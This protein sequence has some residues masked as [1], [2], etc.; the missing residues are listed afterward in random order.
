MLI[1]VFVVSFGPKKGTTLTYFAFW[2]VP[3]YQ[4]LQDFKTRPN[5]ALLVRLQYSIITARPTI[6]LLFS[7]WCFFLFFGELLLLVTFN[8]NTIS[9]LIPSSFFTTI[10]THVI[11]FLDNSSALLSSVILF[12][13]LFFSL[14]AF[15]FLLNLRY[16]F[17]YHY[18]RKLNLLDLVLVILLLMLF[19]WHLIVVITLY[20]FIGRFRFSNTIL[21]RR[22]V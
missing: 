3:F 2:S 5:N 19:N 11:F 1:L 13:I 12:Y 14:C 10:K 15:L 4:Y 9:D 20:I 17:H 7:F 16:T 8:Y 18:F 6:Y 21:K 22:F